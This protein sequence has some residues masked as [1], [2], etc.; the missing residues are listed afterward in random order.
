[1]IFSGRSFLLRAVIWEVAE[2]VVLVNETWREDL[3]G[4]GDAREHPGNFRPLQTTLR[5]APSTASV[6]SR[7][8][9]SATAVPSSFFRPWPIVERAKSPARATRNTPPGPNLRSSIAANRRLPFSPRCVDR[10]SLC[11]R[12]LSGRSMSFC[13]MLRI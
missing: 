5:H 1:M 12:I 4:A 3:V 8:S 13:Y 2:R 9:G 6:P 7:R 10:A 11:S